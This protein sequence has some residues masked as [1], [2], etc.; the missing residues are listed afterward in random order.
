M[1]RYATP[2]PDFAARVR[3]SFGRQPFMKML[4][5]ELIEVRA[6]H[7]DIALDYRAALSQQH[8]YFHGGIIGTLADNAGGYAAFTV[9]PADA[10]ILTVEYKLNIVAPGDGERLI[11][12]GQVVKPG[13]TLVV[14]RVEVFVVKSGQEKLC[15][16]AL[17]TLMLMA[18]KSDGPA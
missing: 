12:R 13:R 18:G 14:C 2:N 5:A 1:S 4:G 6:G 10:S 8:G 16:I 9:A 11:A 15:A 17:A 3:D 7:C